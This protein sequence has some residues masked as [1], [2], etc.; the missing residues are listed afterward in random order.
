VDTFEGHS[1]LD[2]PEGSEG[3][4]APA[5]FADADYEQVR[6]YLSPFDFVEV[7]KGR[8]Q[9]VAARLPVTRVTL[10]HV[11]VDIYA[12]TRFTLG[13]L[14]GRM[15]PGGA[16]VVDDY[17]FKTCPGVKQAVDEFAAERAASFFK[18]APGNGACCLVPTRPAERA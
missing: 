8:I 6:D 17:D 9:D 2:L 4:H 5:S 14:A 15:A 13:L 16:I 18:L 3:P 7:V 12:P 11:D 1:P 10:A